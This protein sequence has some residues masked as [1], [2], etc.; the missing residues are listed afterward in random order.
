M[1]LP[2]LPFG[3]SSFGNIRLSDR[4]YVDKTD[5]IF[6]M[7]KK[8]SRVLLTRPRRFGKS[9]LVSVLNSLFRSGVQDFQDLKIEKLWKDRKQYK[10]VR[11]D[12]SVTCSSRFERFE[13]NFVLHLLN[14]FSEHGFQCDS[15]LLPDLLEKLSE[16]LEDQEPGSLVLLVDEYEAPLTA[17]L[18][19]PKVFDLILKDLSKF[20]SVIGSHVSAFRFMFIT[21]IMN[22]KNAGMLSA[23]KGLTDISLDPEYGSIV[24]FTAQELKDYFSGY[25][26]NAARQLETEPEALLQRLIGYYDGYCFEKTATV[27]VMNPWSVMSFLI[28]PERGFR[29]HW[30]QTGGQPSL[31]KDLLR[32]GLLKDPKNFTAV[33]SVPLGQLGGPAIGEDFS[34]VGLLT[35]TGYLG[36]KSV[37]GNIAI[38][39]YSTEEVRQAMAGMY[40]HQL[41]G[42]TIEQAGVTNFADRL[43]KDSPECLVYVFNRLLETVDYEAYT[44][45]EAKSVLAVIQVAMISVR[46]SPAI[47]VIS[48]EGS[49]LEVQAGERT[50]VLA[51]EYCHPDQ[52]AEQLLQVAVGQLEELTA[53]M[54]GGRNE[55]LR[56]GLCFQKS[57]SELSSRQSY[58]LHRK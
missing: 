37:D 58:L 20:F 25:I 34:E 21:G 35:Q 55:L 50:I 3:I 22:F 40:L 46:L 53:G 39:D 17:T 56:I 38:V 54:L 28:Y 41:L 52:E 10:V 4:I 29:D 14:S 36:I 45:E 31:L 7:V 33:K 27:K 18:E 44:I 23:I 32:S 57:K 43:A 6:S 42:K 9:L 11:L 30:F 47:K 48:T 1:S 51:L 12:F 2:A 5:L 15:Y 49:V 19:D 16:W 24:G 13:L 26:E 8:H